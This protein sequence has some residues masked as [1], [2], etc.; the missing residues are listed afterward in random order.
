MVEIVLDHV[1]K[2]FSGGTWA[3]RKASFTVKD[4]EFFILVGPSGCGKS[5]L[6]HM[7][8]GLEDVTEGEIR[9]DGERINELDPKDR[10][11]ALVFQS[12]ALYPHMTVR[13]NI[14]FPLKLARLAR[15]EIRRRVDQVAAV[16][17]LGPLLDRKPSE[18][19]GGQR[20]R[21]A[22]GRAIV[23]RPRAFLLDEPL[24]N[25]DARLRV[26][27]RA[28]IA[29]LQERLGITTL[30]VTHDQAEA[31]MLGDRVAI[32]RKGEI[33][34]I[35]TPKALYRTPR[36]Q[37]VAG[38]IGSPSM[39]FLNAEISGAHVLSPIG[40]CPLPPSFPFDR[41]GN[42][43][44]VVGIR[45]EHFFLPG[46]LDRAGLVFSAEI[47]LVEWLGADLYL[48]VRPAPLPPAAREN[49]EVRRPET[50]L[51]VRAPPDLRFERGDRIELAFD[52]SKIQLFDVDTGES[53]LRNH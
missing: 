6:L 7:I 38:F 1:S 2:R 3:V 27:M 46:L 16:L 51:I 30:Y 34:Q 15:D 4:G 42:L 25:L 14:A 35:G 47:V 32:L 12:Y 19:S 52:A 41:L 45:P 23:R 29:A 50:P 53:F 5:T 22:M 33:Q 17:E 18:L 20:Q 26:Q 31:M 36:N 37:F 21:V 10:N 9:I 43:S 49:S 24:S 28:E 11:M 39:N 44:L 40:P 13:E 8:A 48:H